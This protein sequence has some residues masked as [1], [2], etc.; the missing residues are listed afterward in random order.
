[1]TD[2]ALTLRF[3]VN[4]TGY[5]IITEHHQSLFIKFDKLILCITFAGFVVHVVH[6]FINITSQEIIF[7]LHITT[8]A[9]L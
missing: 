3:V 1:M 7:P 4:N 2:I 6:V 5:A 9:Q 8:F